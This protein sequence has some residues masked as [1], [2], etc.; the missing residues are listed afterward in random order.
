MG[1]YRV[2]FP[3]LARMLLLAGGAP[4][5]DV[6]LHCLLHQQRGEPDCAGKDDRADDKANEEERELDIC[7]FSI[8]PRPR[9]RPLDA[10]LEQL[11]SSSELTSEGTRRVSSRY[12]R[13]WAH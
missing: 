10:L 7:Q 6:R 9:E 5:H 11:D 13:Q 12:G 4:V 1:E 8:E 3:S 2:P